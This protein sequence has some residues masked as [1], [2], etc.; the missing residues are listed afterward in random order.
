MIGVSPTGYIYYVSPSYEGSKND[1]T[2]STFEENRVYNALDARYEYI[3]VDLGYK[4]LR[5][6]YPKVA[7]PFPDNPASVGE[8]T[9]NEKA[10]NSFAHIL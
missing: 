1:I 3:A 10:F 8:I 5:K 7:E 9:E 6:F 4:G 2:V